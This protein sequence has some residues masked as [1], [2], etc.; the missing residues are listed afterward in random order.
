MG[1]ILIVAEIQNAQIRE[2][3]FELATVAA[4]LAGST[5]REVSSLVLGKDAGSLAEEFA[6]KGGGKVLL[7]VF[8]KP[9]SL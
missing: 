2:A 9:V 8:R 4:K 7:A 1:T 3:S 6:K 5:G